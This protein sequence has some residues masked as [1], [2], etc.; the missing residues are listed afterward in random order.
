MSQRGRPSYDLS[1]V[2][3]LEP[4]TIPDV[5]PQD[6]SSR[7]A[8]ARMLAMDAAIYGLPSV[9]QYAQMYVQAVDRSS[10]SYTGFDEWL[11]QREPATADFT[12]FKTP[13][14]DTLYSNAWLDLS[15]G[16][17]LV[18]IPQIESRYYTLHFLD[19]YSNATNLSSR[20]VGAGGGD[21]L[22]VTPEWS[23]EVPR[24]VTAFRVATP[25]MWI[26]MRILVGESAADVERVR[27]LQDA[28]EIRPTAD[29]G[30]GSFPA[31]APAAAESDWRT[32]FEALDWVL[33]A[34]GHPLQED[35]YV[36]RFRS[37]GIGGGEPLELA[38]LDQST[39]GGMEAG[40]AAAMDVIRNSRAQIGVAIGETGWVTGSAG[41]CGF[42]YLRRALLNFAGTGGNVIAEKQFFATYGSVS[43]GPLD[44][45]KFDYVI[46]F[47]TPPP[48]RGHWS[49]TLYPASTGLFYRN[50]IDRYAIAP[51]TPG[52]RHGADGSLT[53]FIQHERPADAANWLP[54]PRGEFYLDL[55]TWEPGPGIRSGDWRPPPVMPVRSRAAA[56]AGPG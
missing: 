32:F 23:G 20:T 10:P 53:V 30:S 22:V 37:I 40:F 5:I 46:R 51:T 41:E 9:Y 15:E 19:M 14:V 4:E 36:H 42:N 27:A 44:G 52:L 1:R 11:H 45:S 35:A 39:R 24:G 12:T 13:N 6:P 16:P 31:A 29:V 43:S 25:Y 49:L 56:G 28:V 54:C 2:D 21:F 7:A 8:Y 17:A 47:E 48:V 55:R 18:R 34:N 38:R 50:E 33:R 26:L 3:Q